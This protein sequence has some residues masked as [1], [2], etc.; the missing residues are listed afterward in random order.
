VALGVCACASAAVRTPEDAGPD[1]RR[2]SRIVDLNDVP[3]IV[4]GAFVV[5]MFGRASGVFIGVAATAAAGLAVGAAGWLLFERAHNAAERGVFVT[6]TIVLLGGL[7]AY[8]GTSPLLSGCAAALVWVRTPGAADRIIGEDLRKLQHPLVALLLIVAGAAV[9]WNAAMLWMAAPL[10]LFRLTGKLLAGAMA[11]A[12]AD[13]PTG[14]LA[15]VLVPPG[16]IGIAMALNLQQVL[17]E[18][19]ALLLSGITV[20]AVVSEV[21]AAWLVGAEDAS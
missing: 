14:L 10:V 7:G 6:G 9:E 20:A 2:V 12:I 5:A 3:I 18:E 15:T 11:S 1:A 16:V 8:M 21:L 19:N 4:L 17:G 13:V